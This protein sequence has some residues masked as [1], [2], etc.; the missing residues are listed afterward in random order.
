MTD[1]ERILEA[2]TAKAILEQRRLDGSTEDTER[3]R[4]ATAA[5]R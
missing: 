4:I 2:M 3:L 1:P 5:R